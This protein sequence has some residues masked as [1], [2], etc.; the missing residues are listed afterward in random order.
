MQQPGSKN[1]MKTTDSFVRAYIETALWS[2]TDG[3]GTPLDSLDAELST[4][5]QNKMENDCRAFQE[6]ADAII[7]AAIETGQVV[8]G[9][10]FDEWGR[11]AHDFW[12]TRNHHGAGF[13][14]GDWPEPFAKQLTEIA[15]SFGSCDLYVGDDGLIYAQ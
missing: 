4:D 10:D 2:S 8:C 9:P 5:A 15:H 3:E 6:K 11:A 14:D 12:L 7:S 13:W 1:I